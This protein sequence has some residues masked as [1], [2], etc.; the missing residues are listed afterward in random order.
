[1]I[2]NV[3]LYD[4]RIANACYYGPEFVKEL[5]GIRD[6]EN[7]YVPHI[8]YP[9]SQ[10]KLEGYK[11]L[12]KY[13][14]FYQQNPVRF[15]KDFFNIQLLDSQT[16]LMTEA[17]NKQNTLILASRAFG[18]SFWSVLFCMAKQMLSTYPWN[19]YIASGS[20]EQ[21][22]TTFKKLEDIAHDRVESLMNSTGKIFANEVEPPNASGDGFSHNP[23]GFEYHLYNDSFC[24]SLTSNVSRNRG[25]RAACVIYDE[26]S[27]L[28]VELIRVYA[29]FC[30]VDKDFKTGVNEDGTAFNNVTMHTMP[31]EVP[32]QLVYVSSAS[33]TDTEFYRMYREY[34]KKMIMGDPNYFVA[35]IDCE[36]TMRP[37]VNG[38]RI[39][40]ALTREMIN[41]SLATSPEK[42]RREFFNLFSTDGGENAII[43]RGA[44]TRNEQTYKPVLYN[45]TG[46]RK[47]VICYDPARSR[48]NSVILVGEIYKDKDINGDIEYKGRLLNC[49]NL[50]DIGKKRKSPMQT[51]DQVEYLKEVILDYNQGGDENYSNILGIYIDAGSGGGGV[52][53]A[54]YLMED[55]VGKDGKKHKG[56]IDR[57]YSAEYVKKFPGAVDKI[58]LMSPTK[59]KSEMYE[60]MIEMIS[61]NK[62]TFTASYDN[63]GYLTFIDWDEKKLSEEKEKIAKKLK[64]KKLSIDEF[65]EKMNEE[66]NKLENVQMKTEKLDWAEEAALAGIDAL[67]EEIINMQR[68]RRESGKDSF[69]LIPEKKNSLNDDRAYTMAMFGF[70]LSEERR[71]NITNKKKTTTPDSIAN[72]VNGLPIKRGWR[73]GFNKYGSKM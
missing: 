39:K 6:H 27:F 56:L 71:K 24:K 12:A 9:F 33:S 21:S 62:I 3:V 44:V 11:Q 54:D 64:T 14:S 72:F 61:Q 10:R 13:R 23:S 45:D 50:I 49:I 2:D 53:I 70:S 16:W 34:S 26:T 55:W 19:C 67:K 18:K 38:T 69:E 57:D 1:M 42:T 17:W 31:P 30:A 41:A 46:E 15:I 20:A 65:E 28:D 47:I 32:N 25:K 8:D 48:D 63:K 59:Y 36:L 68:I 52:N 73:P 66:L 60:A 7:I 43:R 29:A 58:H 40:S 22:A 4:E 37:T 35:D 51:P 5:L